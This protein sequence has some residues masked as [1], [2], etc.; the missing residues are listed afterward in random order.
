MTDSSSWVKLDE[1]DALAILTLNRP[2][3]GNALNG[4]FFDV[5]VERLDQLAHADRF[6]VLL[7]RAEGP[8]FC[9]GRERPAGPPPTRPTAAQVRAELAKIQLTNEALV[10]F[11]GISIAA[12]QGRAL[13]AGCSL[14]GRCDLTLAASDARLGFPEIIV[15]LP[16]TIVMSYY[17]HTLPRKAFFDLVVTGREISADDALRIGLVSRVVAAE[18]LQQESRALADELLK[19]DADSLRACKDFFRRLPRLEPDDA[20]DYGIAVLAN[21]LAVAQGLVPRPATWPQRR[22][23]QAPPYSAPDPSVARRMAASFSPTA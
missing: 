21:L 3:Q 23:R 10:R 4:A 6:I 9:V 22:V 20:A 5:L 2:D 13:G 18:R 17:G 19:R 14:A 1:H 16:P 12:V 8:D 7:L 11:P 15:G